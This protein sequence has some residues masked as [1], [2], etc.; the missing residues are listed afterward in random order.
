MT[1]LW[2]DLSSKQLKLPAGIGD[3]G[4]MAG[5]KKITA[6]AGALV[7]EYGE[8]HGAIALHAGI[9]SPTLPVLVDEAVYHSRLEMARV[10]EHVVGDVELGCH[11][12]SVLGIPDR[13]ATGG[14]SLP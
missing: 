10:V 11:P 2:R 1:D 6:E 4:V 13:A 12:A 3:P 5:D 9:G 14:R 8:L 7:E